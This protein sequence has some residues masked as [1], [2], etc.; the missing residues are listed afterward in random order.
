MS[1]CAF[2]FQSRLYAKADAVWAHARTIAGVNKELW[3]LCRMT[4]PAAYA[5]RTIEDAPLGQRAF[6]SWILL[7]G[8]IPIDYDDLMLV[9]VTPPTDFREESTML[10][11]RT[12]IHERTIQRNP[13][14][15]TVIDRV[16]FE[17]RIRPFGPVFLRLY[18]LAF[19]NRHRKLRRMFGTHRLHGAQPA[20]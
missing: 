9:R 2:E 20:Q 3:P 19:W 12:W 10:T 15:C 5:S 6:R 16:T 13:V 7:F 18:R 8:F 11:Q 14:G 17:P 1:R 4:Y